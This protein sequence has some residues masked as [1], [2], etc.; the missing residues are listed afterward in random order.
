MS[1]SLTLRLNYKALGYNN[2][3]GKI[4]KVLFLQEL[5]DVSEVKFLHVMLPKPSFSFCRQ[6]YVKV[7][8]PL[9][10]RK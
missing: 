4:V 10:H 7:I 2:F 5:H 6:G 9:H 1:L 3:N 8:A